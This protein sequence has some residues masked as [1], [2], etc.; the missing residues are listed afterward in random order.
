M[1]RSS[2]DRVSWLNLLLTPAVSTARL[3]RSDSLRR[4]FELPTG[5]GAL[6]PAWSPDGNW[7]VFSH[8][9]DGTSELALVRPDGTGLRKVRRSAMNIRVP[10][11]LEHRE[12]HDADADLSTL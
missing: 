11:G 10:I 7:I 4:R 6:N 5:T 9:R 1:S 3:G 8:Q 12:G 2:H